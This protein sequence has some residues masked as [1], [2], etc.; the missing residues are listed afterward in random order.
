M[1]DNPD[2]Q[3]WAHQGTA[4]AKKKKKKV[5]KRNSR[6]FFFL[7]ESKKVWTKLQRDVLKSP[8]QEKWQCLADIQTRW[9]CDPC[10][11]SPAAI[12]LLEESAHCFNLELVSQTCRS[13]GQICASAANSAACCGWQ[14]KW[15]FSPR[16]VCE[17]RRQCGDGSSKTSD[18][19]YAPAAISPLP[20]GTGSLGFWF[21]GTI[22]VFFPHH[23]LLMHS[24]WSKLSWTWY[25]KR[26]TASYF[27][28]TACQTEP[29]S[30]LWW[31][32][33]PFF[34]ILGELQLKVPFCSSL[35]EGQGAAR[36][37]KW[38]QSLCFA[39]CLWCQ[40]M[41]LCLFYLAIQIYQR[42]NRWSHGLLLSCSFM[43]L[44]QK[45]ESEVLISLRTA[46]WACFWSAG[47]RWQQ[48]VDIQ[49]SPNR[50]ACRP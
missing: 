25:E 16:P 48:R 44:P 47:L 18:L 19:I 39:F 10:C 14:R 28:H 30:K 26:E 31:A 29:K 24:P 42:Q 41:S 3:R 6:Q 5:Q 36:L 12:Y 7:G 40:G 37:P 11:P 1:T 9:S 8:V 4:Q 20:A 45:E 49:A 2:Q 38:L 17:V 43:F 13:V 23:G 15:L 46:S 33:L 50:R 22:Y 21:M 27:C 34:L 32:E 35:K